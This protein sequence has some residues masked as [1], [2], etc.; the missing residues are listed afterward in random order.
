M[1]KEDESLGDFLRG[2]FTG[3][4]AMEEEP[5]SKGQIALVVTEFVVTIVISGLL[6]LSTLF[7]IYW[8]VIR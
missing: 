4:E 2:F 3:I 6:G 5:L 8:Y 1:A 7:I